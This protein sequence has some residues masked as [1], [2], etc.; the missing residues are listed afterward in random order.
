MWAC[1]RFHTLPAAGGLF[2]QPYR[3]LR[4]MRA[5]DNVYRA[6][7]LWKQA[8]WSTFAREYPDEWK[9]VQLVLTLREGSKTHV[10]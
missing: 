3:L 1:D 5:C 9:I 2:D 6:L 7:K 8:S 4:W 10:R